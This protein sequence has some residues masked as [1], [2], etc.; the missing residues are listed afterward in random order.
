V[1]RVDGSVTTHKISYGI[2]VLSW[3]GSPK[4]LGGILLCWYERLQL[5]GTVAFANVSLLLCWP[6]YMH[7]A[8]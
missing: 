4:L 5:L 3:L 7:Y 6:L 1:R 2:H 8:L